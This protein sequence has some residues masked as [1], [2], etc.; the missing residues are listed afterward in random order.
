MVIEP[1]RVGPRARCS[2][3][4][5]EVPDLFGHPRFVLA[6]VPGRRSM[7]GV[8]VAPTGG[9]TCGAA[10]VVRASV[11]AGRRCRQALYRAAIHHCE[12]V[13]AHALPAAIGS[14]RGKERNRLARLGHGKP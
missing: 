14:E 8:V 10:L 6:S 4:L 11:T 7:A 1:T 2:E 5:D 13:A 3:L 9:T 12:E